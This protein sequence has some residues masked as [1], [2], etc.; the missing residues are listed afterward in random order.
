MRKKK[1]KEEENDY[2]DE[3]ELKYNRAR[4][5]LTASASIAAYAINIPSIKLKVTASKKAWQYLEDFYSHNPESFGIG[6]YCQF[7]RPAIFELTVK[8]TRGNHK[9]QKSIVNMLTEDAGWLYAFF[10][11]WVKQPLKEWPEY[12]VNLITAA[13][14]EGSEL[15]T[16]GKYNAKELA[17]YC[18]EKKYGKVCSRLGLLPFED[19][20]NFY[21]T[22][23]KGSPLSSEVKKKHIDG[24]S[25]ALIA[26]LV[27]SSDH[28]FDIFKRLKLVSI[29]DMLPGYIPD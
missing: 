5:E 3:I 13:E 26:H 19:P 23:I 25:P 12:L 20:T 24:Q 11:Y 6:F 22:Y 7:I 1:D 21:Q 18:A 27:Y 16:K 2:N 29:H 14:K 15:T 17:S 28:L 4:T 8:K 10:S 9:K